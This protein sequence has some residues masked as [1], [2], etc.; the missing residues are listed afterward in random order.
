MY[1]LAYGSNLHPFRLMQR[2]PSA[3]AIGVVEMP[4][5]Q[6]AFHKRSSDGSGKCMFSDATDTN[7]GMY[8]VLYELDSME[9]ERLDRLEGL[10]NGY[11]EQLVAI[12]L[13]GQIYKAYAYVV[14]CT[15]IDASLAPYH[16]YREMVLLGA[17]YHRVPADYITMI[18]KVASIADP[19]LERAAENE[20]ILVK[21]RRMNAAQ[22]Y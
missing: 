12:P 20:A 8:G 19:D 15:H 11:N 16:W 4:D 13:N 7:G 22:G 1:C 2:V 9:K 6:L 3:K 14:A 18:E 5:K 17:R 10:G 21:M